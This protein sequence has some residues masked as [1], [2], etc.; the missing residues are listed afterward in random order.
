V[1][2]DISYVL[3]DNFLAPGLGDMFDINNKAVDYLYCAL[4]AFEFDRVLGEDLSCKILDKLKVAHAG[5]NQV[6]DRLFS[7]YQREYENFTH[8]RGESIETRFTC[9]VNNKMSN[10]TILPYD[11]HDRVVKL[12]HSLDRIIW[13]AKV[14]AIMETYGYETLIVDEH[15]SN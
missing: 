15:F 2:D 13:S 8:L 11:D 14:R 4:C 7:T 12:L 9:I 5:N 3:K 1:T 10:V 6:K